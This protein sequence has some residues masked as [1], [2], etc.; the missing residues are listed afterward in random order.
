VTHDKTTWLRVNRRRRCPVCESDS[1]CLVSD[2]AVLCMR[3]PSPK[4][5]KLKDG[6]TGWIHATD[7]PLHLPPVPRRAQP[8]GPAPDWT[9]LQARWQAA[10]A[11]GDIRRLGTLLGVS[12]ASLR[13]LG[14]VYAAEHHAWGFPM[15]NPDGEI[16][17]FR[18]RTE[19]GKK[20]ARTGSHNGLFAPDGSIPDML[21]D[22]FVVEGPSD[23]AALLDLGVYAVGRSSCRGETDWLCDICAGRNVVI[24]ADHDE[25]KARPDGTT[26]LPGQEGASALANAVCRRAR[27]TKVIEPLQGKDVR[28]WLRAGLT[29]A[30]FRCVVQ[31]A[32]WWRP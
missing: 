4:E 31:N 29:P 13:R 16:I 28:D 18:L 8:P 1:W 7:A 2:D 27:T 9:A 30:V 15:A 21:T 24:I 11:P 17:G 3:T 5:V 23:C 26:W 25:P 22:L 20:F 6:T 19:D 14:A 32:G 10:T 12:A